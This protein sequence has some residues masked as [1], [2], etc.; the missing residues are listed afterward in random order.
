MSKRIKKF[1]NFPNAPIQE[2]IFNIEIKE[3]PLT[4]LSR[5]KGV[6]FG[7]NYT[8]QKSIQIFQKQFYIG[9]AA[10]T[11]NDT[12][13]T[14]GFQVWE[15]DKKQL[16]TCRVDGFSYNK[17][18]P[19]ENGAKAIKATLQGWKVFKEGIPEAEI[20][21]ISVRN[22]N[23][24]EIPKEKYRIE[25]YF[26]FYPTLPKE[27]KNK[28]T[29]GFAARVALD[30]PEEKATC[31]IA[32]APVR[33]L[34]SKSEV[35]LDIEAFQSVPDDKKVDIKKQLEHLNFIKDEMFF[36]IVTEKCKELFR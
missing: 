21:R 16:Y 30:F 17:L 32:L 36:S 5:L 22:I 33:K 13:W 14:N 15:N 29:E 35:L 11:Q 1:E 28:T 18:R 9:E 12:S 7:D 34:S 23:V 20:Q 25:S 24:I 27:H 2:A 10:H 4:E 31:I 19:Y 26:K 8:E 6:Q 3:L